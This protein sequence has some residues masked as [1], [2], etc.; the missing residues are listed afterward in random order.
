MNTDA[1]GA[2]DIVIIGGGHNGL[3]TAFYLAKAGFKPLVLE[4][5][6][7]VG[8]AAITDEFHP[9]FRCSTL[10]HTAGPIRP[11]IIRDMQLEKHGL[12]FIAPETCV[13]ALTPGGRA[14]SLYQDENKSAQ[15]IAAFS[16][17]DAAKYPEFQNSLDKIS[18]VMAEALATTPPDIDHP[19]SGD[20][21]SMLKTG[22]AVRNLGKRDMYRVLRWGPMAVAD[23]VAEYFET[24]LLRAIIA[25]RGIFGTF[26]GPWS[27]GS[28]LQLLIRAAGDSHP[29]GSTFFAAGGMGA[30]TQAMASAAK[31]AG[32]EIRTAAEVIEIRVRDGAATGVLL[33]TG[34]EITADAIISNADPK[35]TLLKLTDPIHL[36]PDFVQKLQHHRGNGTVAKVNLALSA[37]PN[38]TAL[39]NRDGAALQGRIHI[40]P[41]IDYIE[42]AFDES[43]YG[44]FSR[45]PYLEVTIPSLTDPTLAP[46]GKQV[47]S[48]YMQ[49][50][51]Y[52]LKRDWEEQRKGLGQTVV[53][54]LAQYAP[55][56][57][58]LILTHQIIT[59]QDLEDVY[60]LT[61]GQIFHGDLAL[62][63]FFT[64]RPLLDWARYKTPIQNLYLCGSGT[65]PGAGL[66]GGSGANAAREIV[67]ELKR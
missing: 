33:T 32:V 12:R 41:E 64:M 31:A 46:E 10:A 17:K 54:T 55:N 50:A 34:E 66:T 29:A 14:L 25:A 65:H 48:I 24:E 56:L 19:S 21:W 6:P 43:K 13:T 57:P 61:G 60:G 22:R 39:K 30:L 38:F 40:G 59:P 42:R 53:Q 1:K 15:A 49:Y 28:S 3:V 27:A 63:Q 9:G 67:K 58:E 16:Q 26:L 11:D 44:N 2:R 5:R 8:G 20:L 23:L 35:R 51:P 47:M 45:Q 7:Q 18:K 37:L 36:S 4:R 62:D 52:K